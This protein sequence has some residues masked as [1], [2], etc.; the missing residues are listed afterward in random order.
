MIFHKD[1]RILGSFLRMDVLPL[2]IISFLFKPA[3]YNNV[4]SLLPN[5]ETTTNRQ[6]D[7]KKVVA[8]R[9]K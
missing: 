5:E 9:G 1:N 4:K 7:N 3:M 6:S 2:I 8:E